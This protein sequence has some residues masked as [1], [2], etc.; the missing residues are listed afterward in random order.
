MRRIRVDKPGADRVYVLGP[1]TTISAPRLLR[2][3][4]RRRWS[5]PTCR[6]RHHLLAAEAGPVQTEDADDGPRGWRLLAGL[7]LLYT[8]RCRVQGRVTREELVVR[9]HQPW[10]VLT[11][12]PLE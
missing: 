9:L 10:R 6:T 4:S 7:V 1:A 2:A 12:A 3:W 5:E 8:A 11:S